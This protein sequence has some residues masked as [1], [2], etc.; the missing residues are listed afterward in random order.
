MADRIEIA[1][2]L[3]SGWDLSRARS[4][5]PGIKA[6]RLATPKQMQGVALA[7]KP[8]KHV[9]PSDAANKR[10]P[11]GVASPVI[12]IEIDPNSCAGGI[13]LRVHLKKQAVSPARSK[14]VLTPEMGQ[15]LCKLDPAFVVC[16][17]DLRSSDLASMRRA[18][19]N[20]QQELAIR[21]AA[22]AADPS[23]RMRKGLV[24]GF[25]GRKGRHVVNLP[26]GKFDRHHRPL[27]LTSQC[28]PAGAVLI[29]SQAMFGC[30]ETHWLTP[31]RKTVHSIRT[32]AGVKDMKCSDVHRRLEGLVPPSEGTHHQPAGGPP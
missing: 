4:A 12:R 8:L 27:F 10:S 30:D 6:K 14:P 1:P 3:P 17:G 7:I 32:P 25:K 20:S 31:G 15:L 9:A 26:I 19:W 29:A 5:E 21:L 23:S 22:K 28:D 2:G 13:D 18:T 16:H 24:F 11:A